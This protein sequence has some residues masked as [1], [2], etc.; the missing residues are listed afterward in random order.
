MHS[1]YVQKLRTKFFWSSKNFTLRMHFPIWP[2]HWEV[3]VMCSLLAFFSSNN[4]IWRSLEFVVCFCINCWRNSSCF[5]RCLL[6]LSNLRLS[7]VVCRQAVGE[8]SVKCLPEVGTEWNKQWIR[9][10]SV[11]YITGNLEEKNTLYLFQP[12]SACLF[13]K[14]PEMQWTELAHL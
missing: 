5:C 11:L 12:N 2:L 4:F 9:Q 6:F 14:T 3:L 13:E 7:L 1:F 8:V 10:L